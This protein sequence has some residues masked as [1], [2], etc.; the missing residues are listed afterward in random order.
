MITLRTSS[1]GWPPVKRYQTTKHGCK[2]G[3]RP[4]ACT[5][6][7]LTDTEVMSGETKPAWHS[8]HSCLKRLNGWVT[9]CLSQ[10]VSWSQRCKTTS[11]QM[12]QNRILKLGKSARH[13]EPAPWGRR[14][15]PEQQRMCG[16]AN[17]DI[18]CL[19]GPTWQFLPCGVWLQ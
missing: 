1:P 18:C 8:A 4:A 10:S 16:D 17:A 3:S 6:A 7:W 13:C 14:P 15:E 19:T 12:S 5:T 11:D 9:N 2:A